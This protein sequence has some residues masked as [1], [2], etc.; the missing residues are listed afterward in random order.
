MKPPD[1][2]DV[3]NVSLFFMEHPGKYGL[4]AVIRSVYVHGEQAAPGVIRRVLKQAGPGKTG[5]VDQQRHRAKTVFH[6]GH[7]SAYGLRV[8]DVGLHGNG[9]AAQDDNV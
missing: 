9:P 4:N 2:S 7:H 6:V 3:D 8:G 5:V 1:G